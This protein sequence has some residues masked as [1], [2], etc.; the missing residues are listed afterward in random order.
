MS[1]RYQV[2]S[3]SFGGPLTPVVKRIIIACVSVYVVQLIAGAPITEYFS[4]TPRLV[5]EKFYFWQ[6]L[7]YMFL[8]GSISHVLFNML[9]LF[10]FGCEMERYWGSQRFLRYFLF[11]GVGAGLCVFL[12]PSAY[13]IPT[14]GASGSIY[15]V[16]LAYGMTFPDR[17]IYMFM[18][19]PLPARYVLMIYGGIAFLSSLSSGNSGVSNIAHL[20]G[21]AFGY[22]YL[23]RKSGQLLQPIRDAYYQW[24]LRRAKKKFMV[25]LNKKEKGRDKNEMIH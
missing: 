19:F 21:M 23:K 22:L 2:S 25:Y 15:G 13:W 18:I 20:G 11:T 16:L 10:M 9:T 8:H 14:L 24:K 1:Y 3:I 5:L 6:L 17:I 4:L 12:T 7:T